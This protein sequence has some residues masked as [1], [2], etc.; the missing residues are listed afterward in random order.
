V[1]KDSIGRGGKSG[2]VISLFAM[3]KRGITDMTGMDGWMDGWVG[4]RKEGRKEGTHKCRK[5]WYIWTNLI[6]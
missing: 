6:T 2:R 5:L 3:F 1:V 4:G